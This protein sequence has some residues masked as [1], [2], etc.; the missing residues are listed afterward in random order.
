MPLRLY[1][2]FHDD[3]LIGTCT[4]F[5]TVVDIIAKAYANDMSGEY[6]FCEG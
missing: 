6:W 2:V 5:C 3:V 1:S 4:S